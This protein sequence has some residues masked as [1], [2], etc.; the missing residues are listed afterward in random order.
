[1]KWNTKN[2][3]DELKKIRDLWENN[4]ELQEKLSTTFSTIYLLR[5]EVVWN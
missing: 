3:V 5:Y 2:T 4:K 1:M